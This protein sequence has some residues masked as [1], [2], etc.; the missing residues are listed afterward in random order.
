MDTPRTTIAQL[1]R[2]NERLQGLVLMYQHMFMHLEEGDYIATDDGD[3]CGPYDDV[4]S[5]A[6]ASAADGMGCTILHV[7]ARMEAEDADPDV[8]NGVTAG[9]DYPASL[10]VHEVWS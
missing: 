2:E 7:G 4:L 3:I 8:Y 10:R 5:E 1:E 6:E 9:I